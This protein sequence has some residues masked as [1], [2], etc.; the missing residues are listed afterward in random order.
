MRLDVF[1]TPGNVKP[2]DTAGRLVAIVDVLRAS[3]TVATALGNGAKTV[4]PLEGA[5]EVIFRSKEF[6]RSQIL[7]AGEQKMHPIA[8]FDIG[9]SPQAFKPEVVEGKTILITTTNG[10]RVLLGVQ[11]A[12]DIVIASY[13]N[14]TA[15]LAM[16]KLAARSDT[17]IAIICAGEE[18]SFTLEDAACAG[19]YVRAIPKRAES[20][21]TNDAASASVLIEKKYGDNIEK[22]FKESSHGQALESAGFGEDLAAAAL[23]DSYP[24][25]P[26]YQDRQ[27]TKLG[28]ERER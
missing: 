25:V 18:G 20:V 24:V 7:L 15:V 23:V 4:I 21:V 9:N 12:R 11:G 1:F 17:D 26:I 6:T 10:T 3:T 14:F 16:M 28:P 2:A 22:V 19:R 27:I 13:V 8:G 5:D